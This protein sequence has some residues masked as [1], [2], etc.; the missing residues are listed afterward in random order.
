MARGLG[1]ASKKLRLGR[2]KE[3]PD[4]AYGWFRAVGVRQGTPARPSH[5]EMQ[6]KPSGQK[7]HNADRL[8]RKNRTIN[9][10]ALLLGTRP[11]ELVP[12]LGKA[13]GQYRALRSETRLCIFFRG[14]GGLVGTWP[15]TRKLLGLAAYRHIQTVPKRRDAL[16]N[17]WH[18]EPTGAMRE[19]ASDAVE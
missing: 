2:T 1:L 8:S 12:V 17:G 13:C 9:S 15:N 16:A 7:Q 4:H 18:P 14:S 10:A 19:G 3:S 11:K 5:Q 6:Q